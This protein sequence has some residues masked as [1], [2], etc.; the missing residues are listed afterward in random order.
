MSDKMLEPAWP[1]LEAFDEGGRDRP[2]QDDH[3]VSQAEAEEPLLASAEIQGNILPGFRTSHQMFA[4]LRIADPQR[5]KAALRQIGDEVATMDGVMQAGCGGLARCLLNLGFT[6]SGLRKLVR[7][8]SLFT[9]LAF[10]EGMHR[11]SPLLGDPT[12]SQA[13]GNPANWVVGSPQDEPDMLLLLGA[14]DGIL[15]DASLQRL[16]A[17]LASGFDIIWLEHG[18]AL[19]GEKAGKE[20]FGFVEPISQPAIRGRLTSERDSHLT[21]RSSG[22]HG[23]DGQPLVWPGEFLFGYPGQDPTDILTPGRTSTGGPAWSVNGS[24]L[25]FRRLRQNVDK[26]DRVLQ[27][28]AR[29]LAAAD[30][31]LVSTTP[32]L[33]AAKLMGR[34]RSGAPLLISPGKDDPVLARDTVATNR[35][36]YSGEAACGSWAGDPLG[37]ACPYAA[38]IRRAYPRDDARS[39]LAQAEVQTH[40]LLR[41]GIPFRRIRPGSEERGLLFLAYQTSIERQFEFVTRAWLNNPH[42]RHLDDGYDPIAG[43]APKGADRPFSIAFRRED[44]SVGRVELSLP[45]DLVVPTGGAYFFVPSISALG[46]ITCDEPP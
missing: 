3:R 6:F 9:D 39:P 22:S 5:A 32:D 43:Q 1:L 8:A 7:D 36:S 25:V 26:F 45:A 10:R 17:K 23:H 16:L 31:S 15:A 2:G 46:H 18:S 14:R 33:I 29:A 12:D 42:V 35:F 30:P 21:P 27:D 37:L 38:H 24:Y 20:H 4:F 28:A 41:R 34:W 19:P 40:R 11:R 44:G 13:E